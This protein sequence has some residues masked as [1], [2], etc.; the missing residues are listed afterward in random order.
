MKQTPSQI[1]MDSTDKIIEGIGIV[2]ILCLVGL[3]ILYYSSLPET[4]PTHYG[5][6]GKADG[7]GD[8]STIWL[9]PIIG[10]ITYIG[11]IL[12]NIG[13]IAMSKNP[14]LLSALGD[15][16]PEDNLR[17]LGIVT[18][19][20]RIVNTLVACTFAYINYMTI[21][22]ALGNQNGLGNSFLP[23][24]SISLFG[25]MVYF[26]YKALKTNRQTQAQAQ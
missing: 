12:S 8:K 1:S 17:N 3:P 15:Q 11:I 21:Q 19:M 25:V 16:S 20:L 22:T 10:V 26:V 24:L 9:L 2:A 7:F 13:I 5:A 6:N 4:I 18:K 23:L 14:N